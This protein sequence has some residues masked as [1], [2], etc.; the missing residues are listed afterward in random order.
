[1]SASGIS[2]TG[3]SSG[4]DT[5]S[6]VKQLVAIEQQKVTAIQTKQSNSQLS[7]TNIGTLQGMLTTLSSKATNVSKMSSFDVF[8]ASTTNDAVATVEGTGSGVQGN[9]DVNVKQMATSWKVATSS[10][11]SSVVGLNV[12]GTLHISKS[13]AA[14]KSDSSS[15]TTEVK[16]AAGDTLQDIA[17]KINAASGTG[18][19][20]SIVNFGNGDVRMMINSIDS[21]SNSFGITED[22]GGTVL[23]GLGIKGSGSR[24]VSSFQLR[25]A[26]GGAATS[27]TKLGE[28]YTGIGENNVD[29]DDSISLSYTALGD[30]KSLTANATTITNDLKDAGMRSGVDGDMRNVTAGDIANWMALKTKAAVSL[31]SSG[32]IVATDSAGGAL[33]FTLGMGGT[34]KGTIPLGSSVASTDWKNVLQKGQDAFYTMNGLSV[35]SS[36]ND[37]STTLTGATIHLKGLSA[38]STD[39]TTLSLSRD[40]DGIKKLVQDM[41]DSYNALQDYIKKEST[42][43]VKTKQ[44]SNGTTMNQVTPGSLSYDTAVS[45]LANQLKSAMTSPVTALVG[46]TQYTSLAALGITTDTDTGH[47]TIDDTKFQKAVDSDI[48][49]VKRL[50]ANSGWTD[51]GTATVGGWG[52]NTKSG[53]YLVDPSGDTVDGSHGNRVGDILFST[54]GDSAGLGVT[55][56]SSIGAPFHATFARG[57]GG[58]I[59][60]ISQQASGIDGILTSD[61]T[62]IQKRIDDYGKQATD[63]QTRVDTYRKNLQAQFTAME[64]AMQKLKAQNSA[65]LAQ[66]GG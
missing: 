13:A 20:A 10:Q 58:L 40:D 47:L 12:S 24:S 11:T 31:D 66:I 51:N 35:S 53:T 46:K 52:K 14:L 26:A 33:S 60:Q 30:T 32:D 62:G 36:S 21:G 17:A 18:V 1:M 59:S 39:Q 9:I 57:I 44:D 28:L 7:L 54:S 3:L 65:F 48:D 22:T 41:L 15:T 49:G 16:I 27:S 2:M 63:A 55:A 38:K 8:K 4:I 45:S 19:N 25:Q 34:S 5:D 56:P 23:S 29:K 61:K 50:F 6:L 42:S 43:T 37:D 64:S